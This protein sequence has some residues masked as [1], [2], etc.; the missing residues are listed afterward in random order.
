MDIQGQQ[1]PY[2]VTTYFKIRYLRFYLQI[3]KPIMETCYPIIMVSLPIAAAER[4]SYPLA[5]Q[6]LI[7]LLFTLEI[8]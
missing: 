6:G 5:K 1:S 7:K 3:V 2:V 4:T 8:I